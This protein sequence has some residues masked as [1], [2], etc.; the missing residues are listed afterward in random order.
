MRP[1]KGILSASAT[2]NVPGGANPA[3]LIQNTAFNRK[4][5][6][7][8]NIFTRGII[9]TY[10]HLHLIYFPDT[11]GAIKSELDYYLNDYE[12]RQS[13]AISLITQGTFI[14]DFSSSLISSQAILIIYFKEHQG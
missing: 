6:T 5:P 2:Y 9:W 12:K 3:P 13:Q 10:L 11:K 4:I 8:V 14:D 7:Q 1:Y